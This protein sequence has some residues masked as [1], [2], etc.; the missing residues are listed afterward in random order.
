MLTL[1]LFVLQCYQTLAI[2]SSHLSKRWQMFGN[3][4]AALGARGA[5]ERSVADSQNMFQSASIAI[6]DLGQED[7]KEQVAL[8]N[9]FGSEILNNKVLLKQI[10]GM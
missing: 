3:C 9:S 7:T 1:L 6:E 10:E 5:L 4:N 2:P 8:Q